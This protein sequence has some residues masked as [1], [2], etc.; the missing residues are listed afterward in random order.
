MKTISEFKIKT[1]AADFLSRKS[2]MLVP[3]LTYAYELEF[4]ERP[5][6]EKMKFLL[7]K[8]LMDR[9]YAIE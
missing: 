9:D 3:L 7:K 6:Y 1:K 2:N 5:N 8:I 4:K